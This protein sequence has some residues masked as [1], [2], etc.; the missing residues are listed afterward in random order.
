MLRGEAGTILRELFE[1]GDLTAAQA[2][3]PRVRLVGIPVE[4][5]LNG[6]FT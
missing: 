3:V 5:E 4:A 2:M 6:A 1:F